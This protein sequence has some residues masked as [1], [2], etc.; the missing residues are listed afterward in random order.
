MINKTYKPSI[1]I[2]KRDSSIEIARF[3]LAAFV[4]FT[5][6]TAFASLQIDHGIFSRTI[7]EIGSMSTMAF[8]AISGYFLISSNSRGRW[9][10]TL[11]TLLL[12]LLMNWLMEVATLGISGHVWL[13]SESKHYVTWSQFWSEPMHRHGW[14]NALIIGNDIH[15]YMWQYL[16]AIIVF[17]VI[18]VG[19]RKMTKFGS[20][21]FVIFLLT[22]DILIKILV[23]GGFEE[24]TIGG[25]IGNYGNDSGYGAW[26][27]YSWLLIMFM[28]LAAGWTRLH[29]NGTDNKWGMLGFLVVLVIA[30]L[31]AV[32]WKYSDHSK[33]WKQNATDYAVTDSYG[34][35]WLGTF[36]EGGN[37]NSLVGI[38]GSL[39]LFFGI[40]HL[41]RTDYSWGKFLGGISFSFYFIHMSTMSWTWDIFETLWNVIQVDPKQSS[42]FVLDDSASFG[43][44]YALFMFTSWIITIP[45][46]IATTYIARVAMNLTNPIWNKLFPPHKK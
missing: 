3:V 37:Y 29:Y 45:F 19:F 15:W 8:A 43:F 33:T 11:F 18:A 31:T 26:F 2:A 30:I 14:L 32:L 40:I 36:F 13:G 5:H 25:F 38:I 4:F 20:L 41:P 16:I 44:G 10:K 21:S 1:G 23:L 9:A 39:S 34:N 22:F 42:E 12:L 7:R 6:I 35:T 17:P 24:N 46:A 28:M 27:G